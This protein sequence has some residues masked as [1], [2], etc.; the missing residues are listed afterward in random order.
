MTERTTAIMDI[1]GT[2][3]R[4][5]H[6][7]DL[8]LEVDAKIDRPLTTVAVIKQ[9]LEAAGV[10]VGHLMIGIG[11]LED[12]GLPCYS[13]EGRPLDC[14][15]DDVHC[16]CWY[17]EEGLRYFAEVDS[18]YYPTEALSEDAVVLTSDELWQGLKVLRET[19]WEYMGS[20]CYR[21]EVTY[22]SIPKEMRTD[23]DHCTRRD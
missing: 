5:T 3:R 16:S 21:F 8:D 12:Y 19:G 23:I 17:P 22:D 20:G 15:V 1:Y 4:I 10:P 11:G 14:F 18:T 6:Y 7:D 13:T 9:V 2:F